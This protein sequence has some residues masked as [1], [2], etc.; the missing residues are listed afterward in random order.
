MATVVLFLEPLGFPALP[1]VKEPSVFL[2]Y[3]M[4]WTI[5]NLSSSWNPSRLQ[6]HQISRIAMLR[7][8]NF[9]LCA[10]ASRRKH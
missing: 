8:L 2:P 9:K 5:P 10:L 3:L 7:Q 1:L 4:L 6:K